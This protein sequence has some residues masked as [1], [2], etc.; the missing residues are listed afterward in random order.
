M[1]DSPHHFVYD[2]SYIIFL[3][4]FLMD[5]NNAPEALAQCLQLKMASI[6]SIFSHGLS[7]LLDCTIFVLVKEVAK[8]L[9]VFQDK[10]TCLISHENVTRLISIDLICNCSKQT[11]AIPAH[12]LQFYFQNTDLIVELC[13]IPNVFRR[14]FEPFPPRVHLFS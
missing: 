4:I 6:L 12:I 13:I 2:R 14:G 1:D 5:N 8:K 3:K 9:L 10:L 11:V 7:V